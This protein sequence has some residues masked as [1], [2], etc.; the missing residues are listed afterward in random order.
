M[1]IKQC[2]IVI[3]EKFNPEL[4]SVKLLINCEWKI[5]DATFYRHILEDLFYRKRVNQE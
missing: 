2:F 5:K 3:G 4:H 1:T